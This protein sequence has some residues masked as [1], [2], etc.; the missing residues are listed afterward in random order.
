MKRFYVFRDGKQQG[1]AA[2]K[3]NALDLIHQYQKQ[4]T[5]PFLRAQFSV[6]EG[7]EEFIPYP[8][9]RKPLKRNRKT[10]RH[11]RS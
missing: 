6:I 10:E 9:E 11:T 1:S 4:E 5:P 2:T 3:E 7:T 8:P